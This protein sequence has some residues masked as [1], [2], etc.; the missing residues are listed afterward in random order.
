MF[1][2]REDVENSILSFVYFLLT[3]FF[4]QDNGIHFCKLSLL[5]IIEALSS[6]HSLVEVFLTRQSKTSSYWTEE[7]EQKI[8]ELLSSN[9][10]LLL[11]ALDVCLYT[12]SLSFLNKTTS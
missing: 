12:F 11:L 1:T 8:V 6:N 5:Q 9:E 4:C 2:G 7:E 10:T 3:N